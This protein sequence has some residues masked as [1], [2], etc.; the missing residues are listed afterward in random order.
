MRPTQWHQSY[1]RRYW[2]HLDWAAWERDGRPKVPRDP[3]LEKQGQPLNPTLPVAPPA[4]T[5]TY[6]FALHPKKS[7]ARDAR[8][9]SVDRLLEAVGVR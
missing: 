6:P 8:G 3:V 4:Q 5:L 7:T 2:T 9:R 1:P